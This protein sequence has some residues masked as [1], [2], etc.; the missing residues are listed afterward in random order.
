MGTAKPDKGSKILVKK[1][2]FI[3]LES[4]KKRY[5]LESTA[6]DE[7]YTVQV[8]NTSVVCRNRSFTAD[9]ARHFVFYYG[10]QANCKTFIPLHVG[11]LDDHTC[12]G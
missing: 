8:K 3:I 12:L 9:T 4:P 1:Q 5:H 6:L 7:T 2:K 11:T 10:E